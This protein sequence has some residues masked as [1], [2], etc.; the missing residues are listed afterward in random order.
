MLL[1]E[2]VGDPCRGQCAAFDLSAFG[3]FWLVAGDLHDAGATTDT[4]TLEGFLLIGAPFVGL[5]DVID[6]V[7][8]VLVR[9]TECDA[10]QMPV[11]LRN[12]ERGA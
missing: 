1:V 10:A 4:A 12:G 9:F 3:L 8:A 5:D 7:H 2:R 6:L 11:V